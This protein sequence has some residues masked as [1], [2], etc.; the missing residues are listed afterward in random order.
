MQLKELTQGLEFKYQIAYEIAF[1]F[2]LIA[3]S[4]QKILKSSNISNIFK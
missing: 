3:L 1:G 2:I 4:N